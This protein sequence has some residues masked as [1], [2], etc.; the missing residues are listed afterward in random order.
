M[1][2]LEAKDEQHETNATET[3]FF[4]AISRNFHITYSTA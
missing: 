3:I 2:S 1:K 4:Y